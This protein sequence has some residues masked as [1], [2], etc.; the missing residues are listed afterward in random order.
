MMVTVSRVSVSQDGLHANIFFTVLGGAEEDA[1]AMLE[2]NVYDIQQL[3]N[4]H[5]RM[6]PVPKIRFAIDEE[7]IKRQGVEKSLAELK[8]KEEL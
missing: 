6:R 8:Q 2:K 3:I 4:R 7:E 5:L 1:L